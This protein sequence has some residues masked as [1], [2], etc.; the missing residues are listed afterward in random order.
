MTLV[1]DQAIQTWLRLYGADEIRPAWLLCDQHVGRSHPA[2][3]YEGADGRADLTF[4]ELGDLSQRLAG[5]LRAA[6]LE[7]GDRVGLLLPRSPELVIS[8]L[9]IIRAGG[10]HVP[11]FTAFGPE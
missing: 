6:G 4:H 1:P 5:A 3:S 9:A 11:L 8:L 7:P 2:V 10:V